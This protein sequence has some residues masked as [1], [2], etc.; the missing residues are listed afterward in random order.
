[1]IRI[2]SIDVRPRHKVY[3]NWTAMLRICFASTANTT[4]A[5]VHN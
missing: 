3:V 4:G 5:G 1:V 2:V